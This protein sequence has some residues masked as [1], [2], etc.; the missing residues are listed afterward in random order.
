[1]MR[2]RWVIFVGGLLLGV[3]GYFVFY[4]CATAKHRELIA[5]PAPE[6]AWL[7]EEFKLS[8]AEFQRVENLHNAYLSRCAENCRRIAVK[9]EQLKI[10]LAQTNR[11]TQEIE[12]NRADAAQIRAQ[13]ECQMLEHFYEVS[14]AMPPE[15]AKRYLQWV[16]QKTVLRSQGM[17]AMAGMHSN[18]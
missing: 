10:L 16:Q 6:L 9:N 13:C 14:R 11:V 4:L 7:K 15:E 12:R 2:R 18:E 17:E 3:A 8:D 1:M 5:Q